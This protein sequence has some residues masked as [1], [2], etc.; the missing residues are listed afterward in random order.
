MQ[1]LSSSQA[2]VL[3]HGMWST[4]ETL[5]ELKAMFTQKGYRVYT[6]RLSY[7][8]P[9]VELNN[10]ARRE[11]LA[12]ASIADY[13]E[14]LLLFINT[15]EEPPILVGHSMGGLLAQLVAARTE[16]K[17]MV[18]ISSASPAGINSWSWSVIRTFGH[19]LFKFPLWKRT[20]DLRLKNV[21]YGIAN[22]QSPDIQRDILYKATL[23]S[24]RAS[25]EI[26]MW[27]LFPRPPTRVNANDI[28]CPI[29]L[30]C[31]AQDRITPV[32][33]Q[34]KIAK[35]YSIQFA[36]KGVSQKAEQV[37]LKVI[38]EACHWTIGGSHLPAVSNHIFR[39]LEKI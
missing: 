26:G 34:R 3:I 12:Q 5:S 7:H 1:Q 8:F 30:V 38:D 31:G 15:L 14:D 32:S 17:K 36:S 2:V 18:L 11:A 22:T 23:E 19:N 29:L 4:P 20:T 24:G 21:K 16:V 37:T 25:L 10:K 28:N 13:V 35:K 39:W 6:P 33:V 27:F 9:R